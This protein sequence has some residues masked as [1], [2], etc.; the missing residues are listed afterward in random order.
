M[1]TYWVNVTETYK[2]D[3]DS[4]EEAFALIERYNDGDYS[5]SVKFKGSE[6]DAEEAL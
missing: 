2:V 4:A 3:A 6:Y 5:V 1:N